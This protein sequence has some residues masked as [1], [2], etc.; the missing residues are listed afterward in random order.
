MSHTIFTSVL[1]P[2]ALVIIMTSLG[3]ALTVGD[4]RRVMVYPRGVA[5][6]LGNLLIIS[7]ALAFFIAWAFSLPPE[8]AVGVVLLGAAPGGTMA[9][10][11]THLARGDTALAVTMTAVSSALCVVTVPLFLGIGMTVFMSGDAA[12]P[13]PALAPIVVKILLITLVPLSFGMLVRAA[14]PSFADRLARP[15]KKLAIGFF[16]LVVFAAIYA[17]R[18]NIL[19]FILSVGAAVICLNLLAMGSGYGCARLGGLNRAQTTAVAIELGVHNTTLSMAVGGMVSATM[20]I[21]GAVYG[22]FMFVTAGLF[23]WAM[24]RR[25]T[26]QA[27]GEA[28]TTIPSTSA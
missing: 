19:G 17:E 4:F 3:V 22:T 10:M 18:Q 24:T 26:T 16:V 2:L 11:L 1:L 14:S 15:L 13:A 27:S 21:P 12:A 20:T 23:A 8:L 28:D 9:N 5:I 6:G 25:H 7:P